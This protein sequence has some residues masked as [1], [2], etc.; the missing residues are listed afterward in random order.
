MYYPVLPSSMCST[1][2]LL[3]ET[4]EGLSL[5]TV[6]TEAN[7][8]SWST[9]ERDPS[10]V[11]SLGSV[12]ALYVDFCPAL[13]ALVSPVKN[14]IFLTAPLV[15]FKSPNR[16][17]TWTVSRAGSPVS[18]YGSLLPLSYPPPPHTIY[19]V[20]YL[21]CGLHQWGWRLECW[22]NTAAL[23]AGWRKE[24]R[25]VW[26]CTWYSGRTNCLFHTLLPFKGA[27]QLRADGISSCFYMVNVN[28]HPSWATSRKEGMAWYS[29]RP[30]MPSLWSR[31]ITS[32]LSCSS[33]FD[34]FL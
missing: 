13:A 12:P 1:Y 33:G 29:S 6:D 8:C 3:K 24:T 34:T 18:W 22:P 19:F 14:I 25:Q 26:C 16:P 20:V 10:L 21:H 30:M 5:L 32:C 23:L 17:T 28:N 4:R 9:Y 2:L 7:G 31:P 27:A 15:H 11:G